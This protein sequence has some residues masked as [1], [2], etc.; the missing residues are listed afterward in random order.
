MSDENKHTVEIDGVKYLVG[1]EP[2]QY[3]LP[4]NIQM[5]SLGSSIRY[6]TPDVENQEPLELN[7]RET[8]ETLLHIIIYGILL[9]V[10]TVTLAKII[11][12]L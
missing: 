8:A 12:F 1:F 7:N 2:P 11:L 4:D 5:P 10:G 6:K 9:G 3:R